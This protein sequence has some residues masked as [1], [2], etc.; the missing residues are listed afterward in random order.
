MAFTQAQLQTEIESAADWPNC[1]IIRFDNTS[2]T[3]YTDVGM[4]NVNIGSSIKT[5]MVQVAQSNTAAQA[6]AAIKAALT[7]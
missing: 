1:R 3:D 5:G 2:S 4:Q 6:Y 7:M